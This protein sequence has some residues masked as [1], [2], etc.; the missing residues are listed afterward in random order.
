MFILWNNWTT[1]HRLKDTRCRGWWERGGVELGVGRSYRRPKAEGEAP[2]PFLLLSSQN[3]GCWLYHLPL[4]LPSWEDFSG[5]F[6]E[7]EWPRKDLGIMAAENLVRWVSVHW[8]RVQARAPMHTH[9]I[10]KPS[11][12]L[13]YWLTH[14]CKQIPNDQKTFQEILQQKEEIQTKICHIQM[15]R[16][17]NGIILN[18]KMER[19]IGR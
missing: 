6:E 13:F 15:T 5:V 2:N 11:S 17:Q 14:K 7:I 18:S 1:D 12:Q 8:W 19:T 4:Y 10:N 3:V 16:D 9:N